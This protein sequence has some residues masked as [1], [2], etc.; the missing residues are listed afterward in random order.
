MKRYIPLSLIGSAIVLCLAASTGQAAVPGV[1][2]AVPAAAHA[3][4]VSKT[5]LV[6]PPSSLLV[7]PSPPSLPLSLRT[8]S[9]PT[10]S[11][12]AVPRALHHFCV[13]SDRQARGKDTSTRRPGVLSL[14]TTPAPCSSAMAATRLRPRPL[15]GVDALALQPIE[16]AKHVLAFVR[17]DAG[18]AVGDDGDVAFAARRQRDIDARARSASGGWRSR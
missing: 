17:R 12:G 4:I 10:A 13:P 7:E 14:S 6:S 11:L 5:A 1:K 18:P 16:A 15:P 3:S 9:P 8:Q 2:S